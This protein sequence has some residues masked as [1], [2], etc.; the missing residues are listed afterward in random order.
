MEN[1]NLI[2][3]IIKLIE[4]ADPYESQQMC[5]VLLEIKELI[6]KTKNIKIDM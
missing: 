4:S 2:K 6:E 1:E 5:S 3:D